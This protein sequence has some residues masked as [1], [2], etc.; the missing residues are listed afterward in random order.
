M[1]IMSHRILGS[2]SYP[3]S[4]VQR[5][6]RC[7]KELMSALG[8]LPVNIWGTTEAG[9]FSKNSSVASGSSKLT[10]LVFFPPKKIELKLGDST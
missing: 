7:M 9:H 3:D 8:I 4:H 2:L 1:Q 6:E 10:G 5:N